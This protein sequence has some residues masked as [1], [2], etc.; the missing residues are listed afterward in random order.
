MFIE[1]LA[2]I[3]GLIMPLTTIFHLKR[4]VVKKSS[5]GQSIWCPIGLLLGSIVWL[6]YGITL[7]NFPIITMN[8]F[9]V[10]I[11]ISHIFTI[12]KYRKNEKI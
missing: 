6:S 1:W 4:M 8:V 5:D 11:N 12:L 10:L 3:V 9:W 7:K 2:L